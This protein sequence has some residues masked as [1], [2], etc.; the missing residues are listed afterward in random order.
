[1]T[2]Y[3]GLTGF[4]NLSSIRAILIDDIATTILQDK[5]FQPSGGYQMWKA[6]LQLLKKLSVSCGLSIFYVKNSLSKRYGWCTG[7]EMMNTNTY[8]LPWEGNASSVD[9]ASEIKRDAKRLEEYLPQEWAESN[10]THRILLQKQPYDE[11]NA[12]GY[13]FLAKLVK[14]YSTST[15]TK[16]QRHCTFN[17]D[18]GLVRVHLER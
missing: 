5:A 12:N 11:A 2:I 14:P 16:A 7:T 13:T 3:D 8:A 1:M 10:V 15:G 17:I 9:R 6:F 18:Q 4:P